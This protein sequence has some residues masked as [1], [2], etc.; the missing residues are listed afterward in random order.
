MYHCASSL[1]IGTWT[2]STA[3]RIRGQPWWVASSMSPVYRHLI[4]W[5]LL[6]HGSRFALDEDKFYRQNHGCAIRITLSRAVTI[7]YMAELESSEMNFSKI[8]SCDMWVTPGTKFKPKR[9]IL[10]LSTSIKWDNNITLTKEEAT[11]LSF[12]DCL[13]HLKCNLYSSP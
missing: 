5:K 12:L 6:Q 1:F 10:L 8:S 2:I 7:L 9:M 3:Y 11:T 13:V 4:K